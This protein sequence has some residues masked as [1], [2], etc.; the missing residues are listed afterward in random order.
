[1]GLVKVTAIFTWLASLVTGP[2]LNKALDAYK[3]KLSA[4]NDADKIAADLATRELAVQ[5]REAELQTQYRIASLGRW[6]EPDK[7]MGY[8]VA[9]YVGKLLIYDKVL[10]LGSTDPLGGWIETTAN[11]IVAFYFAKRGF[12]NVARIIKR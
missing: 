9:V 8:A 5:Q 12:E 3:A 1:V 4:G 10:G 11:L 2:L 7:L 6:Y